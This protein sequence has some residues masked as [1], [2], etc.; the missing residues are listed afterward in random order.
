MFDFF[1][2][3]RHVVLTLTLTLTDEPHTAR[4][5]MT[6]LVLETNREGLEPG[7]CHVFPEI[8][9]EDHRTRLVA[10]AEAIS[11]DGT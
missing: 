2:M 7:R 11:S 9:E 5:D 3:E 6:P 8:G 10:L 4:T 1:F